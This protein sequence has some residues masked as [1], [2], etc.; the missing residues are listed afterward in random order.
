MEE[1]RARPRLTRSHDRVLGGVAGG[2]A[3]YFALDPTLVR[4]LWVAAAVLTHVAAL[5]AY[6][7]LWAIVPLGSAEAGP[8]ST[9]A[10]GV[11]RADSRSRTLLLFGAALVAAGAL[12]FA[13]Q[14]ALLRWLGW[15]WFG[16]GLGQ[17]FWPALLVAAGV[18]LLARGRGPS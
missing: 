8:A 3:E 12:M 1:Q 9:A 10:P 11:A 4:V 2:L 14:F 13:N 18:A 5:V 16:V 6:V 17:L 7:L 15:G